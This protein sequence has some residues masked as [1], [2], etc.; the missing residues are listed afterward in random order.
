M[1][2]KRLWGRDSWTK[3]THVLPLGRVEPSSL[4]PDRLVGS[5]GREQNYKCGG[6]GEDMVRVDGIRERKR[7]N[8]AFRFQRKHTATVV[9]TYLQSLC[10]TIS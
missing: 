9:I 5:H 7:G 10:L 3:C 8:N 6:A 1:K 2:F 4:D